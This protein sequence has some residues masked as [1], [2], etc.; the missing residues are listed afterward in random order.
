VI[1]VIKEFTQNVNKNKRIFK[2]SIIH[3]ELMLNVK[4]IVEPDF[5]ADYK[6]IDKLSRVAKL[7]KV[8]KK[9]RDLLFIIEANTK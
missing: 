7:N 8:L 6:I 2:T 9:G 5:I 4:N 1:E 3:Q